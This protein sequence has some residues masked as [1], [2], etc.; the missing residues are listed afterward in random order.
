M[1]FITLS[2]IIALVNLFFTK[3]Q[4]R[5]IFLGMLIVSG[6]GLVLFGLTPPPQPKVSISRSVP[7]EDGPIALES[8]GESTKICDLK[9][10]E[11][12]YITN[13]AD[14]TKNLWPEANTK[15]SNSNKPLRLEIPPEIPQAIEIIGPHEKVIVYQAADQA[16]KQATDKESYMWKVTLHQNGQSGWVWQGIIEGCSTELTDLGTF[17]P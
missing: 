9:A 5:N 13:D 3:Q 1:F 14:R 16:N 17:H 11:T 15:I 8:K 10:G 6:L 12:R 7:D 2:D 4:I